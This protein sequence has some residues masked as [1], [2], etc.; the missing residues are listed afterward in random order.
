MW[1]E[2]NEVMSGSKLVCSSCFCTQVL[3]CTHVRKKLCQEPTIQLYLNVWN[4]YML[5]FMNY[6]QFYLGTYVCNLFRP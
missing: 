3:I 1:Q 2:A 5:F 4:L 6:V